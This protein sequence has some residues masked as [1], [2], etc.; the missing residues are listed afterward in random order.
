MRSFSEENSASAVAAETHALSATAPTV[1]TSNEDSRSSSVA[2]SS[3]LA[4]A[5]AR[6]RLRRW[7]ARSAT[8]VEPSLDT[9]PRY[10]SGRCAGK[11]EANMLL[12]RSIARVVQ[13]LRT[14]GSLG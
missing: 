4:E 1:M 14:A 7:A 12:G 10:P 13:M 6:D 5:S 8:S 11:S 9:C 2:A 3:N